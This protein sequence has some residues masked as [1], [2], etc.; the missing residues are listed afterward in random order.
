[1]SGA[2]GSVVPPHDFGRSA[3]LA[4]GPVAV[5]V[6]AV[7]V[8]ADH[9]HRLTDVAAVHVGRV[10]RDASAA[11]IRVTSGPSRRRR[12]R[13]RSCRRR[14][15]WCRCRGRRRGWS[16]SCGS[17][18]CRRCRGRASRCGGRR[19]RQ[20]VLDGGCGRVRRVV[21]NR[22]LRWDE[23]TTDHHK[24]EA[25]GQRCPRRATSGEPCPSDT[26][27]NEAPHAHP[28][29]DE[30]ESAEQHAHCFHCRIDSNRR[31]RRAA[32]PSIC[33]MV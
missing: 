25:A 15:G 13:C 29:G 9:S 7:G 4:P 23:R 21:V 10:W 18:G 14:R 11:V 20:A 19:E 17:R 28:H 2:G 3:R 16:R 24:H 5:P 1:M 12:R 31:R 27:S 8:G 33:H 22:F 6:E 26:A 30:A 32:M